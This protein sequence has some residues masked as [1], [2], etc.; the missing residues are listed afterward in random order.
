MSFFRELREE[1]QTTSFGR[2]CT[3]P[4]E[5]ESVYFQLKGIHDVLGILETYSKRA[6]VIVEGYNAPVEIDTDPYDD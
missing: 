2:A 1:I 4:Q 6:A 5:R 3:D